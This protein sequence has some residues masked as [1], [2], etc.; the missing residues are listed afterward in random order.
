MT[1][2]QLQCGPAELTGPQ[3][4][5]ADGRGAGAVFVDTA[6]ETLS[7]CNKRLGDDAMAQRAGPD[8]CYTI[9]SWRIH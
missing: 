1:A 4:S 9:L 7:E 8:H 3:L 6:L 5:P 2:M